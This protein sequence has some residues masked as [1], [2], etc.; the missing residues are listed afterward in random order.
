MQLL[1]LKA[2]PR[3]RRLPP[4]LGERQVARLR[5]SARAQLQGACTHLPRHDPNFAQAPRCERLVMNPI[6]PNGL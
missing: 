2:R 1:A 6:F 3:R 4:D 5:E